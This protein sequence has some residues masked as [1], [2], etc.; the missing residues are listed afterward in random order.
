MKFKCNCGF[1]FVDIDTKPLKL[2]KEK[3]IGLTIYEYRSMQ[4][5]KIYK[6]PKELGTVVLI[7]K[8]VIKFK[9]EIIR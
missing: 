7:G 2:S 1:H 6:K 8:E 9:K 5:G 4:T 3:Y